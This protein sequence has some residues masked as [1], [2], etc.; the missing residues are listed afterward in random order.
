MRVVIG[1]G[2]ETAL[3]LAEAL[4]NDH[5]VALVCPESARTTRLD[6]LDVEVVYGAITSTST[7]RMAGVEEADLFIASA[8][9]DENNLVACVAARHLGTKQTICFLHRL[10]FQAPKEDRVVLAESL[11]ID[12]VVV[13]AGQLA[14]EIL[15]I[16][17]IPGALDVGAFVGG[18]VHL[19]RHAIEQGALLTKGDLKDVNLPEGVVLVLVRRDEHMFIPKGSTRLKPGDKV[20]AMG[21]KAGMNRLLYTYLRGERH[22][23]DQ[24][25]ATIVGGGSVGLAVARGLEEAGWDVKVIEQHR[26]RCEEIAPLLKGL[27]LCGDGTD[28]DLLESERIGDDPVLV[29]VTSND[30]KNLLVSLLAKQLGVPRILTRVDQQSNERVFEKVGVD[31]VL[32]ARGA[33][34][35]SV[36]ATIGHTKADL[37]AELEH[38]D[39]EVIEIEVPSHFETTPLYGMNSGVFAIIGAILRGGDVIIPRGSDSVEGGD[40]LLV[41]CTREDEESVREFFTSPRRDRRN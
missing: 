33:A 5:A 22:G 41:F 31:V 37:L 30:E 3:R 28:L 35:Q 17:T 9:D 36:L 11:G 10:D 18:R 4:M 2:G 39:A 21:T 25:R 8:A 32:S 1:G 7:L 27:V 38:G 29:A 40:R 24:T 26:Q 15:K 6:R 13:P 19:L 14:E 23:P 16:V 34:I 20:T 12:Q